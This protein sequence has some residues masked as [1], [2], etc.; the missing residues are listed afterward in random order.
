M[1]W[2]YAITYGKVKPD[3]SF[4]QIEKDMAKYKADAEK[5]GYRWSSG[6]TLRR[7]RRY[8]RCT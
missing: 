7:K 8:G 5:K 4:E 6:G 2:K 3:W 1:K